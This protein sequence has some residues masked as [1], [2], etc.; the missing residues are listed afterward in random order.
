VAADL[1][2]QDGFLGVVGQQQLD[3]A[4]GRAGPPAQADEEGDGSSRGRKTGRLGVEADQWAIRRRLT[5]KR[6]EAVAV[7]REVDPGGLDPD[8]DPAADIDDLAVHRI[9]QPP[10]EVAARAA[11]IGQG[12]VGG[13]GSRVGGTESGE[14]TS[15]SVAGFDE[16]V[17]HPAAASGAPA[18]AADVA[19]VAPSSARRRRASRRA[20]T[21]GSSRGPVQ[22]GQPPSQPHARISSAAPASSSSWRCHNRSDSPIPPGTASYR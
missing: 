21:F 16:R 17:D 6:R 2:E 18:V 9:G 12:I 11:P 1:V 15:E 20:S 13:A 7:E 14:T 8:V 22:D 19:G 10:R 5:G 4:E 3:L